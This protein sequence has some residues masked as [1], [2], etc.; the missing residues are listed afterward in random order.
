MQ[1][2]ALNWEDMQKWNGGK[3]GQKAIGQA[4]SLGK[5][6]VI[7]GTL[8]IFLNGIYLPRDH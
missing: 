5:P 8:V 2:P 7:T 4:T 6:Y 1:F 3:I